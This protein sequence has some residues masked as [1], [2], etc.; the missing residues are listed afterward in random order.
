MQ[1]LDQLL[2]TIDLGT[3]A[4]KTASAPDNLVERLRKEA[5][6]PSVDVRA[7]ATAELAEKTAE[8]G[9]IAL[10]LAEMEQ[11]G[12]PGVKLAAPVAAPSGRHRQ[13]AVFIKSALERGHSTEEV[14]TF[15]RKQAGFG[16]AV[17]DVVS[18]LKTKVA[19]AAAKAK[20]VIGD[21][22]ELA[23][24]KMADPAFRKKMMLPAAGVGGAALGYGMGRHSK[25]KEAP[26]AA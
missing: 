24:K 5:S 7:A 21:V 26:E 8:I 6:A 16:D 17:G 11:A 18:A 10:T 4:E 25:T 14:A 3:E 12:V 19:P 1:T 9:V 13:M 2:D 23:K 20:S 15:L 22:A